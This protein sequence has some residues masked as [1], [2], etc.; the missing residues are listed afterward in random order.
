MPYWFREGE[1]REGETAVKRARGKRGATS[2]SN[3]G[4]PRGR[5]ASRL[6]SLDRRNDEPGN[7]PA[8]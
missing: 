5:N 1:G 3:I 2:G 4:E 8:S 6:E 7:A